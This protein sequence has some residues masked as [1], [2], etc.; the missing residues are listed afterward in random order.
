MTYGGIMGL[1]EEI[2]RVAVEVTAQGDERRR[3]AARRE[4][5]DVPDAFRALT[6]FPDPA[7]FDARIEGMAGVLRGLSIDDS[8]QLAVALR[9]WTGPAAERFQDGFLRP[10]PAHVRNQYA[11]G[12][13]LRSALV[14]QQEIW[15]RARADAE[16]IAQQALRA[17]AACADCTRTEWTITFTVVASVAAVVAVPLAGA[18]ALVAAG[19]AG[20]A[21]V[22]AAT[23]PQE[24]PRTV[25]SADDPAEVVD[26]ARE[27]IRLLLGHVRERRDAVRDA[28]EQTGRLV[29]DQP[30]LFGWS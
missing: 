12:V 18:A 13:V 26:R 7:A 14:A 19:V 4:F 24:P 22:V 30:G 8:P 27:A 5:A 23:G 29:Q 1:A 6:G 16:Q 17:V 3:E 11:V 21:Q 25:F 28:L 20:V 15:V 9:V 2:R 10:W